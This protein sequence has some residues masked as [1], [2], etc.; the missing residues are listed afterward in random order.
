LNNSEKNYL[1]GTAGGTADREYHKIFGADCRE[2][3]P[4]KAGNANSHPQQL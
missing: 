1:S 2:Q 3:S 4:S